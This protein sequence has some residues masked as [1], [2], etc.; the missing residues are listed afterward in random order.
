MRSEF[1]FCNVSL[2][3][4]SCNKIADCLAIHGAYVLDPGSCIYMSE[5]PSYGSVCFAEKLKHSV[6][7]DFCERKTLFRLKRQAEKYGL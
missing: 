6:P 5:V 3:N 2:C 7:A 4:R 1:S